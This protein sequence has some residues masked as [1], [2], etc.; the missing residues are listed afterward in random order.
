MMPRRLRALTAHLW[1]RLCII[2]TITSLVPVAR[3]GRKAF[4]KRWIVGQ[5]VVR[6]IIASRAGSPSA[7]ASLAEDPEQGG[8]LPQDQ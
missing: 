6:G 2:V 1:H 8:W 7:S 3:L 5:T 4:M